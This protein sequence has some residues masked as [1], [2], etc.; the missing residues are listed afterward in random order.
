MMSD[1][2]AD[3]LTRIRNAQAAQ[4][5]TASI[6]FSNLKEELVKIMVKENYLKSYKKTGNPPHFNLEVNLKYK[7]KEGAITSL[8]RLSKPG[9]RVYAKNQELPKLSRGRGLLILSTS[10]GIMT[11]K[12]AL[13][14][15]LGGELI[16]KIT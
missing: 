7:N 1:P 16:L 12:L 15:N 10:H 13:K 5:K 14:K 4:H 9:V 3:L 6:P 8:V 11:N 2:I